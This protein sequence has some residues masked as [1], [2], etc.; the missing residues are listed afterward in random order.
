MKFCVYH[1]LHKIQTTDQHEEEKAAMSRLLCVRFP[2]KSVEKLTRRCWVAHAQYATICRRRNR[3]VQI[4]ISRVLRCIET[5]WTEWD[6]RWWS[7]C[8]R[9]SKLH[10]VRYSARSEATITHRDVYYVCITYSKFGLR[11]INNPY[12]LN[13]EKPPSSD[14][15]ELP[16]NI[17]FDEK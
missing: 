6:G 15:A 14:N 10:E 2:Y 3:W 17:I 7:S 4:L 12:N 9:W 8:S 11:F 16:A 1:E 13:R 5:G